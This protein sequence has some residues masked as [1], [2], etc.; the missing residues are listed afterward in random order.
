MSF[1]VCHVD[2]KSFYFDDHSA[3]H[4]S[5]QLSRPLRSY[6]MDQPRQL[7]VR[8]PTAGEQGDQPY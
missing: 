8:G 6:S 4:M 1:I 7:T 2:F 5:A 3:S